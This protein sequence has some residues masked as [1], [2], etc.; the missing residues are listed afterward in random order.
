MK[1][2]DLIRSFVPSASRFADLARKGNPF[3]LSRDG[4]AKEQH[5]IGQH[6]E[7][8]E[9]RRTS[10]RPLLARQNL[11]AGFSRPVTRD[12]QC[13]LASSSTY[14]RDRGGKTSSG[15][16]T[17]RERLQGSSTSR[18][19]V[20]VNLQW[21]VA[22]GLV[23]GIACSF[24]SAS[25]AARALSRYSPSRNQCLVTWPAMQRRS[26]S[27]CASAQFPAVW[28]CEPSYFRVEARACHGLSSQASA[29]QPTGIIA[30]KSPARLDRPTLMFFFS[31]AVSQNFLRCCACRLDRTSFLAPCQKNCSRLRAPLQFDETYRSRARGYTTL[32]KWAVWLGHIS[33]SPRCRAIHGKIIKSSRGP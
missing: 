15:G 23:F 31:P 17:R 30:P 27:S 20:Y 28:L 8:Q 32:P 9:T 18:E 25:M 10:W 33:V 24:L 11:F 13:L 7:S 5:A 19:I 6:A 2:T 3:A 12:A 4:A 16:R 21:L 26:T 14:S 22:A 29:D 1:E